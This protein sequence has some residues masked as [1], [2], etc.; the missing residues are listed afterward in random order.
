MLSQ[1]LQYSDLNDTPLLGLQMLRQ[2]SAEDLMTLYDQ[3]CDA[4]IAVGRQTAVFSRQ[5]NRYLASHKQPPLATQGADG[6]Y[7]V[8]ITQ[9]RR[10]PAQY[11]CYKLDR[12][13][14]LPEKLLP[15]ETHWVFYKAGMYDDLAVGDR[16]R[17]LVQATEM[18]NFTD[19]KHAR[20]I[21]PDDLQRC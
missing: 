1:S 18:K 17:I 14:E 7:S 11:R 5:L 6:Y 3:L 12:P 15:G 2:E 19:L 20:N 21:Y 13:L 9:V 8:Q 4:G 16:I 10:T